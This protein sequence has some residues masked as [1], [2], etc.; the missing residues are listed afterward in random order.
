MKKQSTYLSIFI[1]IAACLILIAAI[2]S[3]SNSEFLAEYNADRTI[4]YS[5]RVVSDFIDSLSSKDMAETF[6][7]ANQII[8]EST[9][10]FPNFSYIQTAQNAGIN[11]NF[12]NPPFTEMDY[13]YWK[14]TLSLKNVSDTYKEKFKN[15][16]VK[17]LF[18]AINE[19]I[20]NSNHKS[21][22]KRTIYSY[23]I[24]KNQEGDLLDKYILFSDVAEQNGYISAILVLQ[25]TK[26]EII[27]ILL[28]TRDKFSTY[29]IDFKNNLIFNKSIY[30]LDKIYLQKV[31]GSE[32]VNS[33]NSSNYKFEFSP[34]SY[35]KINQQLFT[36]L[37]S[38]NESKIPIFGE[39]PLL[40][41]EKFK[42]YANNKD[43]ET[44]NATILG[45][46]P[47]LIMKNSEYFNKEWSNN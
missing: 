14:N 22:E 25:N 41:I 24:W 1:Y 10:Y 13:L 9:P 2:F 15:S 39:D 31:L 4:K 16:Y 42:S 32:V 21:I 36:Y 5:N 11:S 35:R 30:E 45:I 26:K 28:E 38:H 8:V 6:K 3:I 47:F 46:E 40:K 44:D 18:L 12:F 17:N 23:E 37:S 43:K 29:T 7:I 19:R 27:H 20:K 33:I 34:F